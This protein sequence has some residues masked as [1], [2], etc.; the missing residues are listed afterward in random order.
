LC[1][2]FYFYSVFLYS[3]A[4]VFLFLLS[5]PPFLP[6]RTVFCISISPWCQIVFQYFSFSFCVFGVRHREEII[7]N[8]ME[9]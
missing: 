7:M 9:V 5:V 6:W 2:C 4:R 3:C 1:E 8:K